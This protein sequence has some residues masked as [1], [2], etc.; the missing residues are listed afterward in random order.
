MTDVI[1]HGVAPSTYTRTVRLACEE[2]GVTHRLEPVE[3]GSDKLRSLHPFGKIPILEHGKV[4]VFETLAITR[5]VDEAFKGPALQPADARGRAMM[6][7]WISATL[8]YLYPTAVRGLILPRLVFPSRGV[9]VDEAAVKANLP[10]VERN[11]TILDE[12]LGQSRYFAGDTLSLADLFVL[13]IMPYLGMIPDSQPILKKLARLMRWQD[14]M[15]ARQ[16]A[17]A[18]EPKLAA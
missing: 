1:I 12:A 10:N 6:D 18:T 5:Y 13:P 7:Q 16:S 8:D 15:L 9:P 2:K 14:A 11:L 3:F 17:P 4:R